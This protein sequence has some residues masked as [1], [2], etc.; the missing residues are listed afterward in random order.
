[1]AENK[2][3]VGNLSFDTTE[4]SLRAAFEGLG[5]TTK[6]VN[7]IS[8]RETGRPRGFGFVEFDSSDDMNKAIEGMDG[9]ELDGRTLKVN[10]SQERKPRRDNF[11]GGGGGFRGGRNR[12]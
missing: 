12:Y 1:M 3:Y 5:L 7:I 4:D 8:D 6:S 9:Q 10:Q 2:V 11:G